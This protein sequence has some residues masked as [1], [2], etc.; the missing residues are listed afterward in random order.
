MFSH[1]P[2]VQSLVV[3]FFCFFFAA[4]VLLSRG[5]HTAHRNYAN[6]KEKR[7]GV[8]PW[9]L[10]SCPMQSKK[11]K[12]SDISYKLRGKKQNFLLSN[13]FHFQKLNKLSNNNN[14]N[15]KA[16]GMSFGWGYKQRSI[17]SLFI[18]KNGRLGCSE[19]PSVELVLVLLPKAVPRREELPA[20]LLVHFPH[21]RF[22]KWGEVNGYDSYGTSGS[23]S[24]FRNEFLKQSS[25]NVQANTRASGHFHAADPADWYLLATTLRTFPQI[26]SALLMVVTM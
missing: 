23:R 3:F 6:L 5:D 24:H 18:V 13:F 25:P 22:L 19:K 20:A 21:V 7:C 14:T 12:K 10:H 11:N 2:F 17:K 1:W 26:Y 9:H 4:L 16:L 15:A 8:S